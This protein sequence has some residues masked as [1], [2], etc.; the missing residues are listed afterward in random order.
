MNELLHRKNGSANAAVSCLEDGRPS[1]EEAWEMMPRSE[2]ASLVW[3][4]E[5]ARAWG[6][7][8]PF[9]ERGELAAARKQFEISYA[10]AVAHARRKDEPVKW[11][12]SLGTDLSH[13]EKVL[14]DAL[15]KERLS[16]A[17]VQR[18]LPHFASGA[19]SSQARRILSHVHLK[20]IPD[21][22]ES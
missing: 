5:M 11:T 17:H 16:A 14:M 7:A 19:L 6:Q 3:T 1:V 10:R 8:L 12:P 21:T 2:A 13:R 4:E 22:E 15:K 20:H 9:L 18:L